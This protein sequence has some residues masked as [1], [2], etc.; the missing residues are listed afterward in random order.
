MPAHLRHRRRSGVEIGFDQVAPLFGVKLRRNAPAI[1]PALSR[2]D[3]HRRA[4]DKHR[5]A[6]QPVVDAARAT[7]ERG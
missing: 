1:A 3:A 2:L 5:R 7:P 4:A 6:G